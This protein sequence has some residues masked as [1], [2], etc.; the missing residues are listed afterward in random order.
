M[1]SSQ[2]EILFVC[3]ENSSRSQMAEGFAKVRGLQAHSAGTFPTTYVN[4]LVVQ[5]MM[6]EGIDI[7]KNKPKLL[8]EELAANA[9]L[10]VLTDASLEE[11]LPKNIRKKI[12]KKLQVWSISD[13]KTEPIEGVRFIRDQIK[14]EVDQL[15]EA[16]KDLPKAK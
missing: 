7:S 9:K 3:I 8:S 2:N 1:A 6:E 4:P 13:P 10:V 14:R 12:G 15:A 16:M 11:A 5:A